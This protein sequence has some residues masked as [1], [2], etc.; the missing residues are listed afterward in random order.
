MRGHG[1]VV[2]TL[3]GMGIGTS[4]PPP[5]FFN[6]SRVGFVLFSPWSAAG[7]DYSARSPPPFLVTP[8][9]AAPLS[10]RRLTVSQVV[11]RGLS[12]AR[13]VVKNTGTVC[14]GTGRD[15]AWRAGL[16]TNFMVKW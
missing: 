13:P 3:R 10:C 7:R 8:R 15:G 2:G 12:R 16:L 14:S 6:V 9:P 1:E 4:Q 5:A 11:A